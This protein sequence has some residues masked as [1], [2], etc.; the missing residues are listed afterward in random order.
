MSMR[1][2]FD[3]Q[4]YVRTITNVHKDDVQAVDAFLRISRGHPARG[5]RAEF[6]R[7]AIA[8]KLARDQEAARTR[9]N[10][11]GRAEQRPAMAAQR[12]Q[13]LEPSTA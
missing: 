1:R 2:K 3:G 11:L 4:P 12:E 8:E 13:G 10:G 6:I 7:L 5:C 9:Q